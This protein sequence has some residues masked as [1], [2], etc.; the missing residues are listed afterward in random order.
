MTTD[1][2]TVLVPVVLAGLLLGTAACAS[3][4]GA[5]APSDGGKPS[6][7]KL[8]STVQGLGADPSC[9]FGLDLAGALK[10]VGIERGVTPADGTGGRPVRAEVV[11]SEEARPFPSGVTPT[12]ATAS[13]PARP[14]TVQ[15]WCSYTAG[16]TPVEIGVLAAPAERTAVNLALP[17]IQQ[18]GGLTTDQLVAASTDQPAPGTARTTPGRGTVGIARLPVA[19]GGDLALLV[20]QG[21][22][23]A[24][25]DPALTG[26]PLRA[27]AERLA[28]QL[29]V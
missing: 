8:K 7:A 16:T 13:V 20:S 5:G 29:H 9:P 22:G 14:E 28:A 3:S 21:T 24:A 26:E 23:T 25:P 15:V 12:P 19:D 1:R 4:G 27:L 18:A 10:A 11:P 2:N 17:Y 6:F